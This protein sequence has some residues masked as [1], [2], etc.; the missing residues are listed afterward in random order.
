MDLPEKYKGNL[1]LMFYIS[2]FGSRDLAVT[3]ADEDVHPENFPG[4]LDSHDGRYICHIE[5]VNQDFYEKAD[6]WAFRQT[7]TNIENVDI[8]DILGE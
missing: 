3:K 5:G 8:S 1:T 7:N 2:P 6:E 4:F